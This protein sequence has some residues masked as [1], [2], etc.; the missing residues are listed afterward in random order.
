M[1]HESPGK[2]VQRERWSFA[3]DGRW[4]IYKGGKVV[5]EGRFTTDRAADPA[6]L[7]LSRGDKASDSNLCLYRIEGDA[8]TI[9]FGWGNA[10]P[11]PAFN[12]PKGAK[13]ATC[14]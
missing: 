9:A 13:R 1:G 4:L 10:E 6:T 12:S 5:S 3:A 14:L 7:D 8:L 2:R 11:P